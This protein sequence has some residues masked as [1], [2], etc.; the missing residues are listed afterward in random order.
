M[1]GVHAERAYGFYRP[2]AR[3]SFALESIWAGYGAS[4]WHVSNLAFHFVNSLLVFALASRLCASRLAALFAAAIFTVHGTRPEA[5]VWIAGRFDLLATFFVLLGLILFIQSAGDAAGPLHGYLSLVCMTLAILS[6]ESAF[7]FPLLAALWLISDRGWSRR[8]LIPLLP[9]FLL[10]GTLFALRWLVFG[11]IGGYRDLQSSHA[12]ALSFSLLSALKAAV[13]RLWSVLCFPI[14]WSIRPGTVLAILT[15]GYVIA[16]GRLATSAT[17]LRKLFFSFAFV[18]V[19]VIPPLHML[20]IGSDLEKS[21][22]LYLPSV[23][24]CLMLALAADKLR[25]RAFWMATG[26][27]LTFNFLALEHNLGAWR[28]ASAKAQAAC[29]AAADCVGSGNGKTVVVGLPAILRG[30]YFF[31]NGFKE[32]VEARRGSTSMEMELKPEDTASDEK[33][34]VR[35]MRWDSSSDQLRCIDPHDIK[36]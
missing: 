26:I 19:S 33:R 24:F 28:Y 35:V 4:A 5:V 13:P 36:P 15:V 10:A 20:L 34:G 18:L 22:L 14:N 30:V 11:G 8:H 12:K 32:C 25:G 31:G 16:L 7:I 21:R 9:Y 6:K 29:A 2:I 3:L 17:D 27:V 23:G 1:G